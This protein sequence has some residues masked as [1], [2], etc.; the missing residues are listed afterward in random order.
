MSRP[1]SP[2]ITSV[3]DT[4]AQGRIR[5]DKNHLA[6]FTTQGRDSESD[7]VTQSDASSG[8]LAD[9]DVG[10]PSPHRFNFEEAD[11]ASPV[12]KKTRK[13]KLVP[14]SPPDLIPPS[15]EILRKERGI[16]ILLKPRFW[17]SDQGGARDRSPGLQLLGNLLDESYPPHNQKKTVKE[18]STE[19]K[20]SPQLPSSWTKRRDTEFQSS[21]LL[22]G[23]SDSKPAW[24]LSD[25][26]SRGAGSST[27]P[28]S[29]D[30]A[31]GSGAS[32]TPPLSSR[33]LSK[34]SANS[35]QDDSDV[36]VI[37]E[38]SENDEPEPDPN[39]PVG[40]E[41]LCR[42]PEGRHRFIISTDDYRTLEEGEFLNDII[43]D[44]YLNFLHEEVLNIEDRQ[45][46]YVFSSQFYQRITADPSRRKKRKRATEAEDATLSKEE[47][48]Y[49]RVERWTKN[50]DLFAKDMVIFPI[51]QDS[52]W[53]II[54]AVKPGNIKKPADPEERVTKGEPFLIL[55]DSMGGNQDTAVAVIRQYL[56]AEW[57]AKR[58]GSET[59]SGREMR[60][61]KPEKP[62][63]QN[64]TDCGVF[65]L[66]YVEKMFQSVA[67]Y[68]WSR[69][70][71]L[72]AWFPDEEIT[73]K[74]LEL[75]T[76]I[77]NLTTS[78]KGPDIK[79]PEII[80]NDGTKTK[81][82]RKK[83]GASVLDY[84]EEE[85]VFEDPVVPVIGARRRRRSDRKKTEPAEVVRRKS[86]R[87][88]L[89]EDL[90]FLAQEDHKLSTGY[91]IPKRPHTN[92]IAVASSSSSTRSD[93]EDNRKIL[94]AGLSAESFYGTK[95]QTSRSGSRVQSSSSGSRVQSSSS[96]SRG[97]SSSSCSKVQSSSSCSKVQS[98][99]P[100]KSH[101]PTK[102]SRTESLS[103]SSRREVHEKAATRRIDAN[104]MQRMRDDRE[105]KKGKRDA[106]SDKSKGDDS[107]SVRGGQTTATSSGSAKVSLDTRVG[108]KE[109]L[110]L[111]RNESVSEIEPH[112]EGEIIEGDDVV[113]NGDS[114]SEIIEVK[115]ENLNDILEVSPQSR[116]PKK[117]PNAETDI[118]EIQDTGVPEEVDREPSPAFY[119]APP[120]RNVRTHK[121]A[122][123]RIRD[124]LEKDLRLSTKEEA[125]KSEPVDV[126]INRLSTFSHGNPRHRIYSMKKSTAS[127]RSSSD[128]DT[129]GDFWKPAAAGSSRQLP[130]HDVPRK[131]ESYRRAGA[132][133]ELKLH[134]FPED[135]KSV[136]WSKLLRQK[137][138]ETS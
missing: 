26:R 53:Y 76:H 93:Q 27:M 15:P 71:D 48:R 59:F 52:H 135:N 72:T 128:Y 6:A 87:N 68:C 64:Y 90:S 91:K 107:G 78:Q 130:W 14:A 89:H 8:Y 42:Y 126:K 86:E 61:L 49:K 65:L 85:D 80:L 34:Q 19:E 120:K 95:V 41:E 113:E 10:S 60:L 22:G 121:D 118:V 108:R 112:E 4:L 138:D 17:K 35:K 124:I 82:A 100:E 45:N 33:R 3:K 11:T 9:S 103:S 123:P 98:S 24:N 5:Q 51:C 84:F 50:I 1:C 132:P 56:A 109:K 30:A 81:K 116:S 134:R 131:T 21:T 133:K 136:I 94:P 105:K 127:E 7:W 117:R 83:R 75:A 99:S 25:I 67:Q 32:T 66:H 29:E 101:S 54:V 37:V 114:S 115:E 12:F 111:V 44:F 122:L 73:R 92:G 40:T 13:R 36:I 58:G 129:S 97:Q 55:L 69:L 106:R 70:P 43:I 47:R 38:D 125:K 16:G 119:P 137:P 62:Q 96:G 104:V 2:L 102:P 28:P 46:V 63:Q 77:K 39:K 31:A 110:A 18:I 79:F 23:H 74:R 57:K 88:K 20:S